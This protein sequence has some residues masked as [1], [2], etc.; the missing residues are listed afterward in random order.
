MPGRAWPARAIEHH[1]CG[2]LPP[3]YGLTVQGDDDAEAARFLDRLR[4]G[5][6]RAFEDLVDRLPAPRLRRGAS[7]ARQPRAEAEELAQEVFIR[8]H[9]AIGDF[10]GEAKLSTW[11]YAIASR[12]C[13]NRLTSGERRMARQGEESLTPACALEPRSARRR[14]SSG[15]SWKPRFTARSPS[16][17]R[18]AGI[19]VVLRDLEG[20]S[21]EEIAAALELELGTLRSRLHRARTG[22]ARE[23]RT[24]PAMIC[25]DARE[26]FSALVDD[27]LSRRRARRPLDAHL[28]SCA[29]CRRELQRFRDHRRAAGA[30]PRARPCA[31]AGFV[32]R[33]LDAARPTCPGTGASSIGSPPSGSSDFR[34]RPPR[35]C[36][37]P[38]SPSTSF[39]KRPR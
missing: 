30:R 15:A 39:S 34:S 11:L 19:V 13:L 3:R 31:P 24:V 25:H 35:W 14:R 29:D 4:R 5:D 16:S 18:S 7:H 2:R 33:V 9:Q 27:V 37:W 26:Q 21:Y 6:P 20:L 17:A 32:D 10:R 36:S 22:S 28:S 12:L 1:R 8:V 38:R 23:A